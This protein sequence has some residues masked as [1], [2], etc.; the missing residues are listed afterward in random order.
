MIAPFYLLKINQVEVQFPTPHNVW[1]FLTAVLGPGLLA[2]AFRNN[3]VRNIGASP[4]ALFLYLTPE[5]AG[6]L[7]EIF[8]GERLAA[9]HAFG[10]AL[11]LAGLVLASRGR[12]GGSEKRP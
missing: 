5:F 3:G 2:Y 6:I 12:R 9:F 1:V 11:I 8:L 10:G 4:T 7:G